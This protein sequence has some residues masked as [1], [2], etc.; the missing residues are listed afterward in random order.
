MTKA[1]VH[2]VLSTS[3]MVGSQSE[4]KRQQH[5]FGINKY[6]QFKRLIMNPKNSRIKHGLTYALWAQSSTLWGR[7]INI[8]YTHPV[9]TIHCSFLCISERHQR[10]TDIVF[11]QCLWNLLLL[12]GC[13]HLCHIRHHIR[14]MHKA[15]LGSEQ[16][17]QAKLYI[18][19]PHQAHQTA[20]N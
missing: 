20:I 13:Y 14:A 12:L 16:S 11:C 18:P 10:V 2:C 8:P 6:R 4:S 1:R 17:S 15:Q 19:T 9:P 5:S 7:N 3:S